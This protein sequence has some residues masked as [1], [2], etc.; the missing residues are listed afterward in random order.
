MPK[1]AGVATASPI[2]TITQENV[3]IFAKKIFNSERLL[4]KLMPVFDNAMV[5]KRHFVTDLE[6]FGDEHSFTEVNDLYIESA[7]QLSEEAVMK[8]AD[9]CKIKTTDFDIVFF[10]ST[11]GLSTP[12]IDARLFNRIKMNP[13]IKRV[14]IW[15]LGCAGGA[16]GL[17]RAHDYL[18]A[19]PTHRAL[20]IAVEICGLAFQKNDPTKS[21][22]V[23]AALFGDGAAAVLMVG[24]RVKLP[25]SLHSHPSTIASYSTIYPDSLDV[26]SW[27]ITRE[28][29]KVQLSKNIPEIVTSLV[30][31][32]VSD[33][34][35]EL[36][37]PIKNIAHFI[38]HPGGMK[39]L[40]AYSESL[41][42]P[43][44]K[45][46]HSM[47][48]LRNHGNMSS[49]TV[50]YVLKRFLETTPERSGDYG[51]LGSLGPG[52]SSELLL[53]KWD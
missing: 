15:G 27:R 32:D 1:I 53:L 7:L 34:L 14:P 43:M 35:Q 38:F 39:V 52:F 46:K 22:I 30:K 17:S 23:S 41:E 20:I 24:D 28:G 33:F 11:T 40:Q 8:L 6:W 18:K 2:H 21:N 29:F 49:T 31:K 10:V 44:E 37:L 16:A 9:Q 36:E 25:D 19:Y 47:E 5:E 51:L 13:H 50:Y 4:D 12:S 26:K 45:L 3:K 48:V 42:I